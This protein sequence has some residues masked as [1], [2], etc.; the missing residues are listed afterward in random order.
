MLPEVGA[1]RSGPRI[2]DSGSHCARAMELRDLGTRMASMRQSG[3]SMRSICGASDSSADISGSDKRWSNWLLQH[4]TAVPGTSRTSQPKLRG[5][6]GLAERCRVGEFAGRGGLSRWA[7][8]CARAGEGKRPER[9]RAARTAKRAATRRSQVQIRTMSGPRLGPLADRSP[10]RAATAR[11]SPSMMR[12]KRSAAVREVAGLIGTEHEHKA[13]L[14]F[15][16]NLESRGS[17]RARGR[18]GR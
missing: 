13:V 16:A 9:T 11:Q 18:Q 6:R 10:P 3:R 14:G 4:V 5:K 7:E 17:R 15:K 1:R 2:A 8:R 12:A